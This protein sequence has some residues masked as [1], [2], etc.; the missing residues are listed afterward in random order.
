MVAG[1]RAEAVRRS[2]S[3][4]LPES[5]RPEDIA[6]VDGDT[7]W[8]AK[9]IEVAHLGCRGV[10][11]L[12]P[13]PARPVDL[14]HFPQAVTIACCWRFASSPALEALA[15]WR[16]AGDGLL[17]VTLYARPGDDLGLLEFELRYLLRSHFGFDM[18]VL[19]NPQ[20][21]GFHQAWEDEVHGYRAGLVARIVLTYACDPELAIDWVDQ[22]TR[23][24][25]RIPSAESA[26]AGRVSLVDETGDL[27]LPTL[28]EAPQRFI[29]RG[30]I[31]ALKRGKS[32]PDLDV[33]RQ[34]A[35]IHDKQ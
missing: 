22:T 8:P 20:I 28:Y 29:A 31:D 19:R 18:P 6:I 1:L 23:M 32:L 35:A 3:A 11:V 7:E 26:S 9:V 17:E 25:A 4:S 33:V 13:Q 24:S 12:S 15:Q 14:D 16:P 34:I 27:L 10:V 2:L 21:R 30:L 5:Y